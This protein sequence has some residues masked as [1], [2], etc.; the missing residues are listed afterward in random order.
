MERDPDSTIVSGNANEG[1]SNFEKSIILEILWMKQRKLFWKKRK[2]KR[3]RE[4]R[5]PHGFILLG[6]IITSCP[7]RTT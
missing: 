1:V 6:Y 5:K 7:I 2:K 3:E 4:R